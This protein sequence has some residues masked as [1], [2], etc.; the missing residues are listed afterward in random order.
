MRK[1]AN[2]IHGVSIAVC[3]LAMLALATQPAT[4]LQVD[5]DQS[6]VV[7]P[8]RVKVSRVLP[9]GRDPGGEFLGGLSDLDLD[10][11]ITDAMATKHI[12]GFAGAIVKDGQ[13]Y[14]TGAYGWADIGAAIPVQDSTLFMLASISKTITGT[15]MMQLYDQGLFDLDDPIGDHLSFPVVS[16]NHPGT[17]ITFR[18]LLTHT[19]GMRD[20]WGV[21]PYY[22]GDSPYPLGLY[23][24]DYLAPYGAL[25]D[26]VKNYNAWEPGTAYDYC[27]NGLALVGYLVEAISGTPFDDYCG[28]TI[29]A[30]CD[31]TETA[32]MYADLDP[33]HIAMPYRWNGSAY[34][35]YGHFGYS[36]YPSGQLRT[37][38]VQL[39]R[40]LIMHIQDGQYGPNLVLQPDTA[41]AMKM[42]QV[43]A[44]DPSQGL[45]FYTW[46]L[47]GRTL[48]GHGGGDQGVTTE[49][50]FDPV[51][52]IGVVA[53]TNG[54]A[55]FFDIMDA[56][57]DHAEEQPP[58]TSLTADTQQISA[59]TGGTVAFS[60]FAGSINGG[61]SYVLFGG[62]SG[63][64]PGTPLPGG[65]ATLPVNWD[66]VT[67]LIVAN[68]NT[69]AF[70][71]FYG[72][73]NGKGI[74]RAALNTFGPLPPAAV[75]HSLHFAFALMGPWDYASNALEVELVP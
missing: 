46:N 33:S 59:A 39:A 37:S 64:D 55:Y 4:A 3:L 61:R 45:V 56:L 57:F 13:I 28:P 27:N 53:L 10:T 17:P 7:T 68:I 48:W 26:P 42:P 60:I 29:F 25:Y 62:A 14:W 21:M 72:S 23:M 30:P 54:E 2:P 69:P 51:T 1:A 38:S 41:Q 70:A 8:Q 44:I 19:S 16:P 65:F 15:A 52:D 58:L 50:W 66:L 11:F 22:P 5:P 67:D 24:E 31:M 49:M 63:T 6:A 18:M 34:V 75:G 40:F 20:N 32:W 47:G 36:D 35:P 71:N 74:G 9:D 43:P 73:L 12:P